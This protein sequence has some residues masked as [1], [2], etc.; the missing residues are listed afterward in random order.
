MQGRVFVRCL[1]LQKNVLKLLCVGRVVQFITAL[2][3][4]SFKILCVSFWYHFYPKPGGPGCL[5]SQPRLHPSAAPVL[6]KC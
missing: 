3:L 5:G 6:H 1:L 2:I 4:E